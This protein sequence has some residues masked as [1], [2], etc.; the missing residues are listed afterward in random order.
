MAATGYVVRCT[1]GSWMVRPPQHCPNGHRLGPGRTLVGLPTVRLRPPRG[2]H[3]TW[4]CRECGDVTL[5]AIA[6]L[7]LP[8]ATHS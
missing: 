4:A 2:G 1:D 6:R 3:M 8:T 5:C 7:E